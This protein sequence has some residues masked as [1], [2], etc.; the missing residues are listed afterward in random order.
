MKSA[1]RGLFLS[2]LLAYTAF[3]HAV[4]N[5]QN[6]PSA[7]TDRSAYVAG[8]TVT[9]AGYGFATGEIATVQVTHVDG[10]AE[11]GMGHEPTTAVVAPDGS[12]EVTWTIHR[13]DVAG[14]QFVATVS[15]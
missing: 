11:P 4:V 6:A 3:Q 8:E 9:I 7:S 14:S 15:G 12:F 2:A 10:T 13:A 1:R 5:T